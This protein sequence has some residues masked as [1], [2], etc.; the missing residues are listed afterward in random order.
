ML[1]SRRETCIW[2][3]PSAVP[4]SDWVQA[5]MKRM[6]RII[7]SRAE[8]PAMAGRSWLITSTRA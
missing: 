8:S 4:I 7:R 1:V 5:S 6:C 3:M 2:L